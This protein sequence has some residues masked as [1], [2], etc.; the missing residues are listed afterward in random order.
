[1]KG[2]HKIKNEINI[3][4]VGLMRIIRVYAHHKEEAKT[5]TIYLHTLWSKTS[6]FEGQTSKLFNLRHLPTDL[7]KVGPESNASTVMI[8]FNF[9]TVVWSSLHSFL[10]ITTSGTPQRGLVIYPKIRATNLTLLFGSAMQRISLP[11]YKHVVRTLWRNEP[12]GCFCCQQYHKWN[13]AETF[14]T[15]FSCLKASN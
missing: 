10:W 3:D 15:A 9:V 4:D 7:L 5:N 2:K 12:G 11:F 6:L 14:V 1:M 8:W 13:K